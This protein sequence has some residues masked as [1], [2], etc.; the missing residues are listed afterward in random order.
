MNYTVTSESLDQLELYRRNEA[1]KIRWEPLFLL[2]SWLKVWQ[3][4]FAPGVETSNLVIHENGQI[5]GLAPLVI[6][7]DSASIIGSVNVC[8]YFDFPVIPGKEYS[9]YTA[10]LEHLKKVGI[11]T[12]DAQVARPD[13][14]ILTHLVP[15]AEKS[16]CQVTLEPDELSPE[17]F[18]S[19][20]WDDYLQS[21]DTKQRHELRRKLRRF[22]AAGEITC[23]YITTPDAVPQFME[24]FLKM[25]TESRKDK[26]DFLTTE[27]EVYFKRIV[28][29]MAEIGV[30][31][32]FILELDK[33][34]VATLVAFDYHDSI[35]LYNS[36]F[37]RKYDYLSVGILS[38]A[39]LIKDSVERK[40]KRFDF[41]KGSE[42]Y[43]I[44]LGGKEVRLQK[45]RI[46]IR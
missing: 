44:H 11:R 19:P 46:E 5:L 29:K 33:Q 45:C 10:L 39:L 6:K 31:R 37:D 14:G 43:K 30:L 8:D 28:L 1:L 38:K 35:Y 26:A 7:A 36:G 22:E 9:F 21:L 17:L 40:K 3:S 18:L 34:P 24:I 25:F 41:L 42:P 15:L 13:A 16:G 23:K 4:C 12:L 2:P 27:M 32:G 20:T